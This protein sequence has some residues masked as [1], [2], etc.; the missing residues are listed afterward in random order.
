MKKIVIPIDFS[1]RTETALIAAKE[2]AIKT[3]A[4]VV[5]Y[6]CIEAPSDAGFTTTGE[7]MAPDIMDKVFVH[8][9]IELSNKKIKHLLN[10]SKFAGMRL[11][12]KIKI[13]HTEDDY[14]KYIEEEK[15]DLIIIGTEENHHLFKGFLHGTHA[16]MTISESDCM[17][18]SVKKIE[19]DFSLKNIVFATNF[20]QDSPIFIEHIKTLQ[21]IFD[22]RL[23]IIYVDA[24]LSH[25]RSAEDILVAKEAFLRK[26]NI[27][28]H[29]FKIIE[30]FTEYNGIL[31]YAKKVNA[32]LIALTTHKRTGFHIL[33]GISNDLVEE[34]AFPILTFSADAI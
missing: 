16:R 18:L 4:E 5:L 15:P 11:H 23:H 25:E 6:H 13:V 26:Y 20:E 12:P 29:Q 22:F 14:L 17:V 9:S 27:G 34:T 10:D 30:D 21:N 3:L 32:D 24:L 8:K 28:E 7:V 33:G 19:Q 2:I 31:K 1:K